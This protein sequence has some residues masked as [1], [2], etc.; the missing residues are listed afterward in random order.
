[1]VSGARSRRLWLPFIFLLLFVSPDRVE[2]VGTGAD[3]LEAQHLHAVK[4][5]RA[6]KH[7]EALRILDG[8]IQDFPDNY[9]LHRDHI[10]ITIW[11]GDCEDALR[12]FRRVRSHEHPPYL[13]VPVGDCLLDQNRPNE[14]AALA[15]D[16]LARHPGD[17]SLDHALS[18]ATLVVEAGRP[19]DESRP[20]VAFEFLTDESDQGLREW[21]SRLEG[22]VRVAERT[23]LYARYSVARSDDAALDAGDFDR[24]GIGV[25]YRFSERLSID[26]EFSTD[27]RVSGKTGAATILAYAPFDSWMFT[28]QYT[29]FAEDMP[30]TARA[31]GVEGK[32]G[33]VAA[34][35]NSRDY[36]WY[37][38][39]TLNRYDFSDTNRRENLFGMIGRTF[40]VL[41]YREQTLYGEF[42]SSRNSLA[43]A[44]YFN[45]GRDR[46][47]GIIHRTN[48][49]FES[50]YKRHVDSLFLS[51]GS[52]W[53]EG[54]GSHGKWG[55]RYEQDY[56]F[57]ATSHLN[58]GVAYERNVYD[59][60]SEYETRLALRFIK[61]F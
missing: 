32:H 19:I 39:V 36:V 35:Y 25:R 40:E 6:G 38:L 10:L 17:A 23:R 2:S 7:D 49:I 31:A 12:H 29:T 18:K 1:M 37:G 21:F 43:D 41:P 34:E 45:P 52:Y 24:A 57:T 50:R 11:K 16:G 54:Y 5:A 9:P 22:S 30:L 46:Y 42:Y 59:A 26:Q 3:A 44:P 55:V 13:I 28:G 58:L 51:L 27:A 48:F 20:A 60:Q 33:G 56:D 15:R 14:A 53:Q 47:T 4:L 61:S 8:L